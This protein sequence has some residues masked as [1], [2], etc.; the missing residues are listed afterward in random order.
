[1]S[2]PQEELVLDI[3]GMTCASCVTKVERALSSVS[4]VEEASVNLATRTA[5]IRPA[6]DVRAITDAVRRAGYL[7]SPHDHRAG[8]ADR[9]GRMYRWRGAR[10]LAR[11]V[12][13]RRL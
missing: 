3:D 2:A 8:P 7:A 12:P 11:S 4:R 5:V 9:E 13:V 1:V 6:A 10:A